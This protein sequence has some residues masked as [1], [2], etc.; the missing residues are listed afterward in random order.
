[1]GF[2]FYWNVRGTTFTNKEKRLILGMSFNESVLI[3][4]VIM[5]R[6]ID[7]NY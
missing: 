2:F 5:N 7:N 1:M 6:M 3:A 4:L